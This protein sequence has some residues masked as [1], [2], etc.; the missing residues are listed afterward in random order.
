VAVADRERG[1]CRIS[2]GFADI[3]GRAI[4]DDDRA[5]LAPGQAT[6]VDLQAVQIDDP[7]LRERGRAE[8]R[9]VALAGPDTNGCDLA[10]SAQVFGPVGTMTEV[11]VGNPD[12]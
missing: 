2:L 4:I 6:F 12:G 9:P 10:F 5:E 1:P 11:Y 8:V 7:A 3:K